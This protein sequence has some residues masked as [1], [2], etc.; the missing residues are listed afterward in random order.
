[1][2]CAVPR[3]SRC[4]VFK[5]LAFVVAALVLGALLAPWLYNAGKALAEIHGGRTGGGL[6]GW[7]A[8]A[9]R[10]SEFPRFYDRAVL[11]AALLLL[12]PTIHW[13][14]MGRPHGHYRDTPWSFRFP[15]QVTI[16]DCGQ[17]LRRN[18]RG[19]VEAFAGFLLATSLLLLI[20]Y[21]FLGA[22][23]FT[24]REA[25]PHFLRA[26]RQALPTAVIVAV[27]EETIF[28]GIL[29]GIFLRAMR[30][31]LAISTLS[32]LFAFLHFLKPPPGALIA[33]PDSALAGFEL[34][35]RVIGRFADPLPLAT[36]FATLLAVGIV[37]GHA[38]WR[39]ASL[40]LP[41]GLHAGWVF[42]MLAFKALTS[43]AGPP[44]GHPSRFFIGLTLREGL[45]PAAVVAATGLLVHA[46][47]HRAD[48]PAR[49]DR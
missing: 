37:L 13:L 15:D 45:I 6:L 5:I 23:W 29:L 43:P 1:M 10:R 14:R 17:P 31:A 3:D 30:P 8:D 19:P 20:G 2:F 12:V 48:A 27:V 9:C 44:P 35:G 38:R 39:T 24:W 34:L 28:R 41:A 22:G 25:S 42:G 32:F 21:A 49:H 47:T 36:E 40:W 46:L 33:N 7:L 26:A 16:S 18:P 11:L 4:D